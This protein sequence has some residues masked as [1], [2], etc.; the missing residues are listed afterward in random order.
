M[1]VKEWEGSHDGMLLTEQILRNRYE[2]Y[3]SVSLFTRNPIWT[4]LA[5]NPRLHTEVPATNHTS[6]KI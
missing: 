2:A 6:Q 3:S 5:T 4:N 1:L